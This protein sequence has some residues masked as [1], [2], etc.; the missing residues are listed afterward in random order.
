MPAVRQCGLF[1]NLEHTSCF[2]MPI[3]VV[4]AAQFCQ[5]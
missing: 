5:F 1:H 4:K 3:D 2:G